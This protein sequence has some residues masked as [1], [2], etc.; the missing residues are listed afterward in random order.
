MFPTRLW[1][2]DARILPR[3]RSLYRSGDDED[4][5]VLLARDLA[6]L[7]REA[8]G[9]R[10]RVPGRRATTRDEMYR[11]L[12]RAREY[13][14]ASYLEPVS[15][16]DLAR[17]A[18]VS[19]YHF[20]RAFTRVFGQT[21][22]QYRT[23]LRLDRAQQLLRPRRAA[24]DAGLP[25]IRLREPGLLQYALPPPLRLLPPSR[26]KARLKKNRTGP[27]VSMSA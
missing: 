23:R 4:Q 6:A 20:H 24:G 5:L 14:H 27:P 2:S 13:L 21:P 16:D 19:P 10:H 1:A 26:E 25:G 15:L 3:L 7:I 11:R 8:R 18:G 12:G 17:V 22:Q 9:E